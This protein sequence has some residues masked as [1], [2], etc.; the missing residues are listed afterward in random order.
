MVVLHQLKLSIEEAHRPNNGHAEGGGE[1]N[2]VEHLFLV[3][4]DLGLRQ[5]ISICSCRFKPEWSENRQARPTGSNQLCC[6][7][8]QRKAAHNLPVTPATTTGRLRS[9]ALQSI[10]SKKYFKTGQH[11]QPCSSGDPETQSL[12]HHQPHLTGGEHRRHPVLTIVSQA[13][14]A[15]CLAI[16]RRVSGIG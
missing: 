1:N 16:R 9:I 13:S 2:F 5:I 6:S 11:E 4:Y 14:M 15:L 10:S 8:S 7:R 12:Q 3:V